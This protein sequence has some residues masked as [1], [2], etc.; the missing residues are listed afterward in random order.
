LLKVKFAEISPFVNLLGHPQGYP[1][2]RF[3]FCRNKTTNEKQLIA[4]KI[5]A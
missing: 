3:V 4:S 1:N 2:E 5:K